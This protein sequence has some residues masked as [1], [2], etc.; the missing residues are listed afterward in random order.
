MKVRGNYVWE[1]G[2]CVFKK[3]PNGRFT[4]EVK[5]PDIVEFLKGFK[6]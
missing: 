5:E 1:N 4:K 3:D 6:K 2:K